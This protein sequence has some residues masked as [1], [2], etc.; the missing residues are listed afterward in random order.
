M[1]F[2]SFPKLSFLIAGITII[3][4]CD[5]SIIWY[6][7]KHIS[8]QSTSS[9]QPVP[10]TLRGTPMCFWSLMFNNYNISL[11]YLTLPFSKLSPFL[12]HSS[13]SCISPT[14][15]VDAG[16]LMAELQ[17]SSPWKTPEM[18]QICLQLWPPISVR[19]PWW[20]SSVCASLPWVP[21]CPLVWLEPAL[22]SHL[23]SLLLGFNC[24]CS[25]SNNVK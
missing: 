18:S 16:P 8:S 1:F 15:F 10:F 23:C 5:W 25:F 24:C 6:Y 14:G 17:V 20:S 19:S 4:T 2:S 21:M 12:P 3:H 11:L 22:G 7:K 13:G 9:S